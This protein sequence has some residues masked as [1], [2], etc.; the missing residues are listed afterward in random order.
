MT[1]DGA[2]TWGEGPAFVFIIQNLCRSFGPK[3]PGLRMTGRYVRAFSFGG[4]APTS[5]FM[6][7]TVEMYPACRKT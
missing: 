6:P 2:R 4:V 5:H 1:F 7:V 3:E